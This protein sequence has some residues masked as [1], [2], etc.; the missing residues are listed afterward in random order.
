MLHP[1]RLSLSASGATPQAAEPPGTGKKGL[2][3]WNTSH[4]DG[5]HAWGAGR[6]L[7]RRH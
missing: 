5:V 7:L 2:E 3:E 6:P 4:H 1:T